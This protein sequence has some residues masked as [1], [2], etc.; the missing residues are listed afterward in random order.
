MIMEKQQKKAGSC[1]AAVS[2]LI[3]LRLY[4][5]QQNAKGNLTRLLDLFL[6]LW[7][8]LLFWAWMGLDGTGWGWI[9]IGN[10]VS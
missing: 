5:K 1:S 2:C 6:S 10:I 9:G 3:L 4:C 8:W 7:D